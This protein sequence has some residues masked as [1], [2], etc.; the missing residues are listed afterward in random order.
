[1]LY[2]IRVKIDEGGYIPVRG[3]EDDAGLDLRTPCD[4]VVPAGGSAVIDTKTHIL[5][6]KGYYGQLFSKSGLNVNHDVVSLG[7]TIDA[8]YTGSIV[9]KLYNFGN[10]DYEFK[11]GD[12]IVQ[13]VL[14]K[15]ETP[16]LRQVD[17]F[18]VFSE[19]GDNG[20]GSTGR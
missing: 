15:C 12:K 17:D 2:E 3:H 6:P 1:M 20:F 8:Y 5:I 11:A 16:A 10:K 4:V 7:G 14:Q 19:R 9:A 18:S 13:M